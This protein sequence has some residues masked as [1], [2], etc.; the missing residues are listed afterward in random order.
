MKISKPI[1]FA[2]AK[3]TLISKT[4]KNL[5]KTPM[6]IVNAM[7]DYE[8]DTRSVLL[9][10]REMIFQTAFENPKIGPVTETLKWGEPSYL[11]EQSK[12][13][14]TLRLGQTRNDKHPAIFVNC[15]TTLIS[16]FKQHY[17]DRF[18]YQGERA[19]VIGD[20]EK[21][22]SE[23]KHCIALVLTYHLRK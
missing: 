12:S 16:Q 2:L 13:G 6:N 17:G 15:K 14:S 22:K 4:M 3:N 11:T 5:P 21:M 20:V 9:C 1:V 7:Q 18:L 23:L 10:L 19:L 8:P